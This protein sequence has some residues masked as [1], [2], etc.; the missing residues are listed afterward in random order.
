MV[1]GSSP[2]NRAFQD[3]LVTAALF[4]RLMYSSN[5]RMLHFLKKNLDILTLGTIADVVS[6]IVGIDGGLF[7]VPI[8]IEIISVIR[9]IVI[10]CNH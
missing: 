6:L 8:I 1:L 2:V 7:A 3:A 10:I 9:C 5:K 4:E